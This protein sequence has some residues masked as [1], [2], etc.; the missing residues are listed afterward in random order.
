MAIGTCQTHS[1]VAHRDAPGRNSPGYV[2]PHNGI[3]RPKEVFNPPQVDALSDPRRLSGNDSYGRQP[4]R[5]RALLASTGYIANVVKIRYRNAQPL[6]QSAGKCRLSATWP[7]D[8][9]DPT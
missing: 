5:Q 3:G 9:M 8:Y 1:N 7:A 6:C 2:E 4:L